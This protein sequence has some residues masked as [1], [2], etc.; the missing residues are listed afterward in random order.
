M[1]KSKLRR[2]A[3]NIILI[4]NAILFAYIEAFIPVPIPGAKLGL[5]N[6]ISIIAIIYL[7]FYDVIFITVFRCLATALLLNSGVIVLTFSLSAGLLSAVIMWVIYKK[8]PAF[9]SITGISIIGAV[10]HNIVQLVIAQFLLKENLMF[11][12]LPIL[13]GTAMITGAINGG[14]SGLVIKELKKKN[15]CL[16]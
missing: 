6:I 11:Y 14:I 4:C 5:A 9:F 2:Q 12:Y 7:D 15:I 1:D 16:K 3:I 13:L 8:T 10:T